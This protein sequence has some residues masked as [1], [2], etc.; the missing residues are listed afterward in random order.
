MELI[1]FLLMFI[2]IAILAL[3][4]WRIIGLA[5]DS[6]PAWGICSLLIPVVMLVFSIIHWKQTKKPVAVGLLCIPFFAA[7]AYFLNP[8]ME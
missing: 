3:S 4:A 2:G 6:S 1:S 5:F 8:T 7:S